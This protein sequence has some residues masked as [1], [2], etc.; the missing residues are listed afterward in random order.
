SGMAAQLMA[1]NGAWLR[2]LWRCR[3]RATNSLPVPLSP[4]VSTV[5][6]W[7]ATRPMAL[8]TLRM[9]GER[10]PNRSAA[11][12]AAGRGAGS[13]GAGAGC[14]GFADHDAELSEI[15]RLKE[16]VEGAPLRRLD[17]HL[18]HGNGAE[19][20]DGQVRGDLA[21]VIEGVQAGQVGQMGVQDDHVRALPPHL[22]QPFAG[23]A[24]GGHLKRVRAETLFQGV[25]Y[26][27]ITVDREQDGH[28]RSPWSSAYEVVRRVVTNWKATTDWRNSR[29][30]TCGSL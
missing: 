11:R 30:L 17:G 1:R 29:P 28:G 9:A 8:Y 13:A 20:N 25:K 24:G 19:Q 12:P 7:G 4:R 21:E 14:Q 3:A 2:W 26:M 18:R 16:V 23:G 15:D 22:L 5:R 6:A 10:P 27:T